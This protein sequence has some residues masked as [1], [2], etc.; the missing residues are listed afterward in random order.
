MATNAPKEFHEF[1]LKIEQLD[2]EIKALQ[3]FHTGMKTSES[4][5]FSE[6]VASVDSR[7]SKLTDARQERATE[8]QERVRVYEDQILHLQ[9]TIAAREKILESQES[10]GVLQSNPELMQL[11]AKGH[12]QLQKELQSLRSRVGMHE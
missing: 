12:V 4:V 7:L 8:L 11:F 1:A 6:E 3:M 9:S 10:N 2:T 5:F